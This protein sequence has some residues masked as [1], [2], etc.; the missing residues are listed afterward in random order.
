M[1]TV[2]SLSAALLTNNQA[3]EMLGIRPNTLEI[4]RHKGK[5]PK[6]V[7]MGEEKQAP[8]RYR[9][10][11][12]LEWL[13]AKTFRSTSTYHPTGDLYRQALALDRFDITAGGA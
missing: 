11:D 8:I 9:A 7:K 4:W 6:F 12:I 10:I 2:S 13:E 1:T 3:A 5:G